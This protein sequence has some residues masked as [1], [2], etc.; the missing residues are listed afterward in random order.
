MSD[1]RGV[2]EI[3]DTLADVCR[4]EVDGQKLVG[5][6]KQGN[7]I[8]K[9]G[10]VLE[11]GMKNYPRVEEVVRDFDTFKAEIL[12]LSVAEAGTLHPE[13]EKVLEEDVKEKSR[14]F[15]F[16]R[17]LGNAYGKGRDLVET[18]IADFNWVIG[19]DEEGEA[20]VLEA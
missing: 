20:P 1:V 15:R 6:I 12:D 5:N 17:L 4:A 10:A 2:S 18:L 9:I 13:L 16:I 3:V 8:S 19:K 7:A 14:I 11:V